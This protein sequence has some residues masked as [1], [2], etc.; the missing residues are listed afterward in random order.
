MN[1]L[2]VSNSAELRAG[3]R[4]VVEQ[5]G[6]SLSEASSGQEAWDMLQQLDA[7]IVLVDADLSEEVSR[8][9]IRKIRSA[10]LPGY[11]YILLLADAEALPAVVSG[12]E[13]GADDFVTLPVDLLNLK[14]RLALG[15]RINNLES[16]LSEARSN[17]KR[18]GLYDSLT[19]LLNR[20]ALYERSIAE[21]NRC[22]RRRTP[23][24]LVLADIDHFKTINDLYGHMTGD[25]ALRYVA[26]ILTSSIRSYDLC[27]RWGGEEF[28]IVMP[29]TA[30]DEAVRAAERLRAAI[31]DARLPLPKAEFLSVTVSLGVT[32][33]QP[34]DVSDFDVFLAQVDEALYQAKTEGRNRVSYFRQPRLR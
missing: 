4:P 8:E 34:R 22:G 6:H 14:P 20:R 33:I 15:E 28:L 32:E 23:L 13:A 11:T 31:A 17:L 7:R 27:G 16:V 2:V 26:D 19:G 1:I 5:A 12:L 3:L 24:S 25:Q 10:D 9:L 29:D 21:L 18:L 30:L